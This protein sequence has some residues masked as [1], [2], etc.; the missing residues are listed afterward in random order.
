M[1]GTFGTRIVALYGCYN[2]F[3][4]SILL[5][6]L[7][8]VLHEYAQSCSLFFLLLLN[9]HKTYNSAPAPGNC[10]YYC[11]PSVT[12]LPVNSH[13][14]LDHL[15]LETFFSSACLCLLIWPPNSLLTTVSLNEPVGFVRI[16]SVKIQSDSI[17][18][19]CICKQFLQECHNAN[20]S[21]HP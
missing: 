6:L 18:K 16:G 19:I 14:L 9:C 4:V 2:M 7:K 10:L 8:I 13:S 1:L 15:P 20:C 12:V 5:E 21:H 11:L 17:F 3:G